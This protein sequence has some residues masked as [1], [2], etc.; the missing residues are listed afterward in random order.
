MKRHDGLVHTS[1]LSPLM[2]HGMAA[3]NVKQPGSR[4]GKVYKTKTGTLRYG[5]RGEG[6]HIV[7]RTSSDKPVISAILAIPA[8]ATRS[9]QLVAS[10]AEK[11]RD[12]SAPASVVKVYGDNAVKLKEQT[13]KRAKLDA[14]TTSWTKK[15]HEDAWRIYAK[16]VTNTPIDSPEHH[17]ASAMTAAHSRLAREVV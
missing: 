10:L 5:S 9:A 11:V 14:K 12:P 15:D 6:G 16:E 3:P 2:A 8:S 13:Y 4:G 17:A 1:V 7:G